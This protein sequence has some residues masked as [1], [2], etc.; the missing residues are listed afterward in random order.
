MSPCAQAL[1]H[2]RD[3]ENGAAAESEPGDALMGVARF[4]NALDPEPPTASSAAARIGI[5]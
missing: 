4:A 2:T 3:V 5:D 1:L